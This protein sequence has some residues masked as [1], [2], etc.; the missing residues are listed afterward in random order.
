MVSTKARTRKA[1]M[2][3]KERVEAL[4][5]REKPDR[6]PFWPFGRSFAVIHSGG[7]IGDLFTGKYT[8]EWVYQA[9][10]KASEEFDWVFT[11][12]A[13]RSGGRGGYNGTFGGQI[14]LPTSKYSQA[15]YVTR[16][17]A[18]TP[19]EVMALKVPDVRDFFTSEMIDF[20]KR[21]R[22]DKDDNR[23][24]DVSVG[25]LSVVNMAGGIV[26]AERLC[27]WMIKAPEVAHRV[28]RLA[29]DY[30]LSMAQFIKDTFGANK[31][32]P[33]GANAFASNQL[34][35]PKHF[36]EFCLPYLQEVHQKILAM[37]F[38]HLR[39]H[40]CGEQNR[41]LPYWAQVPL[42]DPGMLWVGH[43]I[44]LMTAAKY[45]PN[46]IIAGNLDTTVIQCGTP[47]EVYEE[48]EKVIKLGK[49]LDNGFVLCPACEFPPL[50]PVDNVR[51]I[52][53]SLNDFGWYD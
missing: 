10:K 15:V 36:E 16:H 52:T 40:P 45:F 9:E 48:A 38:K 44:D 46:D 34:I 22:E 4:L 32:M 47:N 14:K 24:F 6:V 7:N 37:G 11:P 12:S 53:R 31:G 26:G 3:N 50:A 42:G 23:P 43:E 25:G 41:N 5:R 29:A 13:V 39:T 27:K 33:T 28:L 49:S 8:S 20:Y 19:E 1:T 18:E 30:E 35:S 51:A 2:T 21:V 17:P